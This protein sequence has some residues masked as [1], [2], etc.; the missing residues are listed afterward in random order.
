MN[1]DR[2]ASM[3][4]AVR[5]YTWNVGAD[6]RDIAWILSSYDTWHRNPYY[7]GEPVPH[8]ESEEYLAS[9]EDFEES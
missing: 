7:T 2:L 5:E 3:S 9:F 8:P 4:D 1:D 6:R